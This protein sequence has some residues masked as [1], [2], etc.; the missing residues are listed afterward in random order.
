MEGT[1]LS[2][3][4]FLH[5]MTEEDLVEVIEMGD[6][7]LFCNALTLDIHNLETGKVFN[8]A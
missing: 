6:I 2:S 5:H 3:V 8:Q 4:E 7:H 1:V